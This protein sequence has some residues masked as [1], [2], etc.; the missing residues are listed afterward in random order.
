MNKKY[1]TLFEENG[2]TTKKR[3][4]HF[5]AQ[6]EHESGLKP[7][8]ENLNYSKKRL[9]EVFEKYFDEETADIY[10][11]NPA[12]IASRVYSN[13]MGNGDEVS[14]EGWKYRGRGFIQITG[15]YNY[16]ELSRDTKIDFINNPELLLE[17]ANAMISA[18][19]Y[20]NRHNLNE[21]ADIDDIEGI[22]KAIN[23]GYNG[24]SD[25][26]EIYN[27]LTNDKE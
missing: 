2:L 3:I 1:K 7:I 25:R 16:E 10:A 17:E 5:L 4:N 26:R 14:G 11:N 27:R 9:L 21:L 23:G 19:W 15:K 8:S 12:K 18:I 22:T 13:R 24:L 6:I 20:W